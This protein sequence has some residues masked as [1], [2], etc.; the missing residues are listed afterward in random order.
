MRIPATTKERIDKH[1][2]QIAAIR[3]L[4]HEGMRLVID[5]RK[6][7]R[8]IAAMQKETADAQKKTDASLRA[9]IE[10]LRGGNG[11]TNGKTGRH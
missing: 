7:F 8:V 2:R 3:E 11:H 4:I 6:D 9:L 10:S 1:G 5:T